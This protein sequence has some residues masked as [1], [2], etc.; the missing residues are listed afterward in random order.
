[1]RKV[2][3]LSGGETFLVSLAM[4]LALAELTRGQTQLDSFFIDEGFGSL[5]QD[6]I[7]EVYE[8]LLQLQ[9][10]GKQIG[11]ISHVKDL[12]DR[13]PVNINLEKKHDGISKIQVVFN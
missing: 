8:L 5:D 1:M 7:E 12:T 10:S 3:T 9:N 13:I 6:T 2:S 4:A 11:I